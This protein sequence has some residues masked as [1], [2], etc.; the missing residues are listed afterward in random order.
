MW[1]AYLLPRHHVLPAGQA[2]D[3]DYYIAYRTRLDRAGLELMWESEDGALYRAGS[4]NGVY[5]SLRQHD[6][7][8]EDGARTPVLS[9]AE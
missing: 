4:A 8:A 3:G 5:H 2:W 9:S 6:V 7:G 1:A